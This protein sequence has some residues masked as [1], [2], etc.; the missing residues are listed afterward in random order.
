MVVVGA[1]GLVGVRPAAPAPAPALAPASVR[2]GH[3]TGPPTPSLLWAESVEV[4]AVPAPGHAGGAAGVPSVPF[5]GALSD[6]AADRGPMLPPPGSPLA[7]HQVFRDGGQSVTLSDGRT[8]WL[9]SDTVLDGANALAVRNSAALSDAA[10]PTLVVDPM[11]G[12]QLQPLVG[13]VADDPAIPNP[14]S[15][16]ATDPDCPATAEGLPFNSHASWPS[17]AAVRAEGDGT[18]SVLIF[19]LDVCL[20]LSGADFAFVSLAFGV[21]TLHYDPTSYPSLADPQALP[22]LQATITRNALFPAPDL[23]GMAPLVAGGNVHLYR[24]TGDLSGASCRVA[25]APLA[26]ATDP[27]GYSFWNGTDWTGATPASAAALTFGIGGVPFGGME[28]VHDQRIGGPAAP[29]AM[30]YVLVPDQK[31]SVRTAPAPEGPWSDAHVAAYGPCGTTFGTGCYAPAPHAALTSDRELGLTVVDQIH[32]TMRFA[33]I[34][35]VRQ[36]RL[37]VLPQPQRVLDTRDGTGRGGGTSPLPGGATI[38]V[39]V[40]GGTFG[41]QP[42]PADATG[43]IVNLTVVSQGGGT[44]LVVGPT[45]GPAPTGSVANTPAGKTR[46]N[47]MLVPL[48]AAGSFDLTNGPGSAHVIVDLLGWVGPAGAGLL[49]AAG[50]PARILDTRDGTGLAGPGPFG[51]GV[52]IER[53]A[54][55]QTLGGVSI[56]PSA[57]GLVVNVTAVQPGAATHLSLYPGGTVPTGSTV[58][59]EAGLTRANMAVVALGDGGTYGV[60]NNSGAVDVVIDLLGWIEPAA[61]AG[62]GPGGSGQTLTL[63]SPSRAVDTRDGTGLAAGGHPGPPQPIGPGQTIVLAGA[64]VAGAAAPTAGLLVV[65]TGERPTAGTHLTA[66]PADVALP[67]TSNVN[68]PAGETVANLVLVRPAADGTYAVRN[69]SGTLNLIVDV[70]GWMG[71]PP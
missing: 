20:Y 22:A 26:A 34:P 69:N 56:P 27:S 62:A 17:G 29:F 40:A 25:R 55:G 53:V 58:N 48:G 46:A 23:F 43:A 14:P 15:P 37:T 12:G 8:L 65:L 64:P 57:T 18:D 28:L 51:P 42:I 33:T 61:G 30:V 3:L 21:A 63:Q 52:S 31:I 11:P 16:S 44:H 10:S 41:G 19:Y 71:P 6:S 24:C 60:R 9:F 4:G 70:V 5:A 45:G 68:L 59:V 13:T 66:A 39:P 7:A 2:V 1:T 32:R 35:M 54:A 36:D 49:H 67:P 47:G 38:S 50:A